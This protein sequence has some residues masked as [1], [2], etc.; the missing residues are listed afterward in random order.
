[1]ALDFIDSCAHIGV[2]AGQIPL[3]RKWTAVSEAAIVTSP[4][5][6]S[7]FAIAI[8]AG[9]SKTLSYQSQRTAGCAYYMPSSSAA[10]LIMG[11]GSG[12]PNIAYLR[13]EADFTVS[14][15]SG[16]NNV[17]IWNSGSVHKVIT[18]DTFHYYELK[19]ILGG[20]AP[21]T[22]TATLYVD[23]NL[24]ALSQTGNTAY[25]ANQLLIN[26]AEMNQFFLGPASG[27]GNTGYACDIYVLNN[28]TVDLNGNTATCTTFLGDVSILALVPIA[29]INTN[30]GT[31]PGGAP[32]S[33]AL[34]DEIPP[35]DDTTYVFTPTLNEIEAFQFQQL[36]GFIGSIFGAQLLLYCKK[37]DE[38][39]RTIEGIVGG[40]SQNNNYG[41]QQY[42]YDYYDYFI[43]PLDSDNGVT[44]TPAVYNAENFGAKLSG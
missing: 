4:S 31:F 8:V 28:Q 41:L 25:N 13:I 14:I 6:K 44:W 40:T 37:D 9:I 32:H 35:D 23:G 5:R 10:A 26:A 20:G 18:A 12:G 42:L 24:W 1:M 17:V 19:V 29:D 3:S 36:V 34:V 15:Y 7:G 11:F 27:G 38:G 39:S 2:G 16:G 43:F 30:W 21:I 33:Y 22:V